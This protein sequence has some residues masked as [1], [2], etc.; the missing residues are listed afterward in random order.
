MSRSRPYQPFLFRLLHGIN[1]LLIL[2]SILTGFLVYNSYDGRWGKLPIAKVPEIIDIHG[3]IAVSFFLV[4]PAFAIYSLYA[5]DKRLLQPNSLANI[6]KPYNLHRLVNTLMLFAA[7]L[8]ALSGR[9]MKEE[10]LP[11]GQ[12]NHFG[13]S[14]HLVSW[15]VIIFCLALH[16]LMV[17]KVGGIPLIQSMIDWQFR[18]NDSPRHWKSNTIAWFKSHKY[19]S[20]LIGQNAF[21]QI[22]L[23]SGLVL[24]LVIPIFI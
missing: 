3:T 16:L 17:V 8:A 22:G 20:Q 13:Y 18:P 24:A 2:A 7:T 14:L 5:G 9:M 21:L 1:G 4:I 10:W 6:T 15:L 12:L 19:Y 11:N 23:F